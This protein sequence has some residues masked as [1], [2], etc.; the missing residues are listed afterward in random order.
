M[1]C[2]EFPDFTY[3]GD[4]VNLNA[5]QLAHLRELLEK[6]L[7]ASSSTIGGDYLYSFPSPLPIPDAPTLNIDDEQGLERRRR[8]KEYPKCQRRR[9]TTRSNRCIPSRRNYVP[10]YDNISI[11]HTSY[12]HMAYKSVGRSANYAAKNSTQTRQRAQWH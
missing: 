6:S 7:Q 10:R 3:M 4:K 5:S 12:K 2:N 11:T 8:K 9:R 1:F